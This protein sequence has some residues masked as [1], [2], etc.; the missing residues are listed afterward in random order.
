[1]GAGDPGWRYRG[2]SSAFLLVF[3]AFFL[4]ESIVT[5]K[6]LASTVSLL[7][8]ALL[9]AAEHPNVVIVYGDDVG[10]GDVGV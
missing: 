5:M 10:Y 2:E 9:P 8:T 4:P 3:R 1:M 7:F 6:F